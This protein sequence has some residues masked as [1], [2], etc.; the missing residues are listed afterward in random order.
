M[1]SMKV[2]VSNTRTLYS[3][4]PQ[5]ATRIKDKTLITKFL[6]TKPHMRKTTGKG[7][8][9][10]VRYSIHLRQE[11]NLGFYIQVIHVSLVMQAAQKSI[12]NFLF[13]WVEHLK[14]EKEQKPTSRTLSPTPALFLRPGWVI[15]P[16]SMLPLH[17]HQAPGKYYQHC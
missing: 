11:T 8:R 6:W 7:R 2:I 15:K 16:N 3:T 12:S 10:N 9:R 13:L 14:Q 1:W 4:Y 17:Y 5:S